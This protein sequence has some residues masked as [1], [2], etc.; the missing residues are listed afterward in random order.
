[1]NLSKVSMIIAAVLVMGAPALA[2]ADTLYR[3]LE[4]GMNGSDV[5]SLQTFLAQDPSMYPQ[6]LVTNYFGVYTKGAVANFQSRNDIPAVGRVGPITLP[7]INM[8]MANGMGRSD[9]YA[10]T[11]SNSNVNVF[12]N[13]ATV[14]W[15]TSEQTRGLVYWSDVPLNVYEYPHSVTVS[16]SIALT[17]SSLRSSQSIVIPNLQSNKTYYYFIQSTDASG[18]V[19]V[20]PQATFKTIQ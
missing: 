14:S 15:N 18:N 8:Q 13:S 5:G 10:P 2:S 17:D 20:V 19:S 3:Q 9:V 6:G 1:M 4:I 12:S 11:I 7:I 16:G